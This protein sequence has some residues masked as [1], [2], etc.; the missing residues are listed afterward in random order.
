MNTSKFLRLV[1][2]LTRSISVN[3]QLR[4]LTCFVFDVAS[5]TS[6]IADIPLKQE[7]LHRAMTSLEERFTKDG[8]DMEQI[9]NDIRAA[10]YYVMQI[11]QARPSPQITPIGLNLTGDS[12]V[13][14]EKFRS[15]FKSFLLHRDSVVCQL[16]LSAGHDL[17]TS[18]RQ[19]DVLSY[20]AKMLA[21]SQQDQ[22]EL[23][24][25]LPATLPQVLHALTSINTIAEALAKDFDG[26]DKDAPV[27]LTRLESGTI[28]ITLD[29][30]PI[31]IAVA[32]FLIKECITQYSQYRC[33]NRLTVTTELVEKWTPIIEWLQA[34][35]KDVGYL[36][37][38]LVSIA[39][40]CTTQL[41]LL[42]GNSKSLRYQGEE[43][44]EVVE[45]M[46]LM[47]AQNKVVGL[48]EHKPDAPPPS[49][50]SDMTK[51]KAKPKPKGVTGDPPV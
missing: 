19:L 2:P 37:S 20:A 10:S 21:S 8:F 25:D 6:G 45:A 39:H 16:L 18:L 49:D 7:G 27:V 33:V 50:E 29:G 1:V 24:L 42:A 13:A 17:E 5:S 43:V 15:A 48:L 36:Q 34:N 46:R 23:E 41:E 4:S 40:K 11:D 22:L 12:L 31:V 38:K 30:N 28:D 14:L 3:T 47:D 9:L 44:A 32:T 51:P 35:G 26:N